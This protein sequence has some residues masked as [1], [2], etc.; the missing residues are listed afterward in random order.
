MTDW[1]EILCP[2]PVGDSNTPVTVSEQHIALTPLLSPLGS[3]L[4][5]PLL[6]FAE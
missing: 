4:W 6:N 5:L 3:T 2:F 1:V